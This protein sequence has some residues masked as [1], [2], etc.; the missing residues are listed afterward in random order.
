MPVRL[1]LGQAIVDPKW[2]AIEWTYPKIVT[3]PRFWALMFAFFFSLFNHYAVQVHQTKYFIAGTVWKEGR[4]L[5]LVVLLSI[6]AR[7][8]RAFYLTVSVG[9]GRG[10]WR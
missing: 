4:A 2:A 7:F 9:S 5:A 6:R 8:L 1:R 3:T 10:L